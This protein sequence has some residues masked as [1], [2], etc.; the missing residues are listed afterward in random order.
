VT[1]STYASAQRAQGDKL[2]EIQTLLEQHHQDDRLR[3]ESNS[4]DTREVAH[5]LRIM[6]LAVSRSADDRRACVDFK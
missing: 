5:Y 4:R 2:Q 6:C 3:A 1:T